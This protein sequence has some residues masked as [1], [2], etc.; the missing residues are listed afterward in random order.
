MTA[1]VRGLVTPSLA[2]RE[3]IVVSG[4]RRHAVPFTPRAS[5][6]GPVSPAC[7]P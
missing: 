2:C 1:R 5:H 7:R 4:G 6:A 3:G